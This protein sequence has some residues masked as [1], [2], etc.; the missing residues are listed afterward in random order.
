VV[1]LIVGLVAEKVEQLL[2]RY[3]GASRGAEGEP[4]PPEASPE[5]GSPPAG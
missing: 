1:D 4:A 2:D 3:L 5:A